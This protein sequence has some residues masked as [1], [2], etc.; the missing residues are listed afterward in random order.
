[1]KPIPRNARPSFLLLRAAVLGLALAA[2]PVLAQNASDWPI[3]DAGTPQVPGDDGRDQGG[4]AGDLELEPGAYRWTP[5]ASP[6]GPLVIVVSLPEQRAHVYRNGIRIGVS[7]I[8][9]GKPGNET[10]TGVFP[11]LQKREVHH[12]NLYNNAPMPYMQRLTWDGIA[13][14]AGRIPGYPASHGCVRLPKAFA[15]ILFAQTEHGGMVVIADETSHGPS[16]V[17]PSDRAPVDAYTGLEPGHASERLAAQSATTGA[18]SSV[19]SVE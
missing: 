9:S 3:A 16:V 6:V 14:H 8:S 10:P 7:T 2:A 13:L 11:I 19:A 12:S 5:E 4:P 18:G 17:W 1:M 15:K